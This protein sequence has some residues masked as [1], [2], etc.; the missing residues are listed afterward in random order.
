[1]KNLLFLPCLLFLSIIS[2]GQKNEPKDKIVTL[3]PNQ[4]QQNNIV[5]DSLSSDQIE[6]IEIIQ[7]TFF[8]VDSISL[9]ESIDN[10]K[11]DLN[12]DEE[13]AIWLDMADAYKKYNSKHP[14]LPLATKKEVYKL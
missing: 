11:R 1:M 4:I 8:E 6:K 5:H 7:S 10:F 13:I 2:C 3:D 12:P 14:N 9:E